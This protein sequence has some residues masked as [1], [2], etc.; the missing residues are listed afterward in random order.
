MSL[1][2]LEYFC[3]TYKNFKLLCDKTD[4]KDALI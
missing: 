1:E 4:K 2:T 3:K